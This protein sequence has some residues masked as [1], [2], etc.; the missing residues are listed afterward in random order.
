MTTSPFSII[1]PLAGE[2]TTSPFSLFSLDAPWTPSFALFGVDPFF[3]RLG[4]LANL[5]GEGGRFTAGAF[6]D[7]G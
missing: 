1:F 7:R 2:G 4:L 3:D 5:S 6:S